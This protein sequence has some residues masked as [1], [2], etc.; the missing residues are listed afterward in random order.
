[1]GV[2]RFYKWLKTVNIPNVLHGWDLFPEYVGSF[3]F[4]MNGLIHRVAQEVFAYGNGY[5]PMNIDHVA[6]LEYVIS[7]P[8]EILE[9][10]FL[11]ALETK[12]IEIVTLVRP[13]EVLILAID[14]V[15]PE[16][17]M[18]Q[19]RQRR[20][21]AVIDKNTTVEEGEVEEDENGGKNKSP[22]DSNSITPGTKLMKR[23]EKQI[24][25]WVE[26]KQ[27]A[28]IGG[29]ALFPPKVIYSSHLVP[30]EGEQKIMEYI[31]DGEISGEGP[32]VIYGMD[33]D[34]IML[35]LVA[36]INN[37]YL[38]RE[39]KD[40]IINIEYLKKYV[41]A[42]LK[43]VTAIKDFVLL[44]YLIGND[45]LPHLP[46]FG[47]LDE[48]FKT[49]FEIYNQIKQPLTY[50][51]IINWSTLSLFFKEL[52]QREKSMLIKEA[53]KVILHPLNIL[54]DSIFNVEIPSGGR[55]LRGEYYSRMDQGLDYKSFRKKWYNRI[56]LPQSDLLSLQSILEPTEEDIE[57]LTY[58]YLVGLQWT[59]T[60]YIQGQNKINNRFVY[61][62]HYGPLVQDIAK[63]A[64]SINTVSGYMNLPE[65]KPIPTFVQLLSVL[66]PQSQD[67]LPKE[68]KFLMDPDSPIADIYPS[69]VK[70]DKSGTNVEWSG[71]VMVPFVDLDRIMDTITTEVTITKQRAKEFEP[72]LPLI[73]KRRTES[74]IQ[75]ENYLAIAAV[76]QR[77]KEK[78]QKRQQREMKQL[79]HPIRENKTIPIEIVS[80]I[81]DITQTSRTKPLVTK[82][83]LKGPPIKQL[84]T[85]QFP[86]KQFPTKQF[87]TKQFPTKQLPTKQLPTKQLSTK[88]LSTKQLPTKQLSTKQLVPIKRI[89]SKQ[90]QKPL[91]P[92]KSV[93]TVKNTRRAPIKLKSVKEEVATHQII[94]SPKSP[95]TKV[96][97]PLRRR[98]PL[99]IKKQIRQETEE[100]E[101]IEDK[102]KGEEE[103]G[104]EKEEEGEEKEEEGEEK[105]RGALAIL[106]NEEEQMEEQ[107]LP[108][109][110]GKFIPK[111]R[112]REV[113]KSLSSTKKT[114]S[115][116]GGQHK[117]AGGLNVI[118]IAKATIKPIKSVAENK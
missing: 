10:E 96:K 22:F 74:N 115:R 103:E 111:T 92:T 41:R 87:P 71:V 17:K 5:D 18:S 90:T 9:D 108:G 21:K 52:A 68:I 44:T 2:I 23:I 69:L 63:L 113:M 46:I 73:V 77:Q 106:R 82:S 110:E 33:A 100:T 20:Y 57:D 11:K 13:K 97:E 112:Q 47:D 61:K 116:V 78:L 36:P 32:H 70:I 49:L 19:Q 60:Y 95:S 109:S 117:I 40:D 39:N 51:N 4:D 31:R 35:S 1:M 83:R 34:L 29:D 55:N 72:Q 3:S 89:S 64:A 101:E 67:L 37:I 8:M 80:N 105:R 56:F 54:T 38:M 62:Y 48:S 15:A 65:Q 14:G 16:A 42:E 107:E 27:M 45:F 6:R 25:K 66:P 86:T 28:I 99:V 24:Y 118:N 50:D 26:E 98:Q 59:L 84:P 104:E 81:S 12:F 58:N 53:S 85:K 94:T 88:Q 91:S 7:T 76:K 30:G 114:L 93:I 75:M 43:G 79:S 102:E